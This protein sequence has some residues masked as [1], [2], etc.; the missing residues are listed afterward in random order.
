MLQADGPVPYVRS[1]QVTGDGHNGARIA[2][3]LRV[4]VKRA[5]AEIAIDRPIIPGII[6]EDGEIAG[7]DISGTWAS[8]DSGSGGDTAQAEAV[9]ECDERL[10]IHRL[11]DQTAAAA[12]HR[13]ALAE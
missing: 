13:L 2:I 12:K 11:V 9:I 5:A 8:I 1:F 6:G 4:A 7:C 3:E 10:P